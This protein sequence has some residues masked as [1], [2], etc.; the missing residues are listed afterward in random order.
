MHSKKAKHVAALKARVGM[1][2]PFSYR[3]VKAKL[4]GMANK[5]VNGR[6]EVM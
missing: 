3:V 1:A 5:L 6:G 4:I 2:N